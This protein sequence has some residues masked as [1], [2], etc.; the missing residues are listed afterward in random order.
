[1][2]KMEPKSTIK[3][4]EEWVH[5]VAAAAIAYVGSL[6]G[7]DEE[8]SSELLTFLIKEVIDGKPSGPI[9]GNPS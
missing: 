9:Q 3:T 4:Q 7:T 8:L 2:E 1:M 5:K 6:A